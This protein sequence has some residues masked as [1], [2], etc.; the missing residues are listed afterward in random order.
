MPKAL[1]A[2]KWGWTVDPVVY[3]KASFSVTWRQTLT[4][5]WNTHTIYEIA[6]PQF[7]AMSLEKDE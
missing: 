3:P 2:Q 1:S 6:F 5:D 7:V 4:G